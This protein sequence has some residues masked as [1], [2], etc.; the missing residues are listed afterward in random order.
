MAKKRSTLDKM[1]EN[2]GN[3]WTIE[4]IRKVCDEYGL[5]LAEPTRGSHYKVSSEHLN[6]I[7]TVPYK[8]PIKAFYIKHLVQ[9]TLTHNK[10][11]KRQEG[12]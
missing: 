6:G 10:N 8:R 4:D 1:R 5:V 2:P 3:N 12:Q 11:S 9:M 7:L